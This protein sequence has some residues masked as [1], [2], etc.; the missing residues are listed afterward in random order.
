MP[1]CAYYNVLPWFRKNQTLKKSSLRMWLMVVDGSKKH[2]ARRWCDFSALVEQEELLLPIE[3]TIPYRY[4]TFFTMIS[5]S[6]WLS[7]PAAAH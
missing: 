3:S 7:A 1:A 6:P 4:G 2:T 5:C